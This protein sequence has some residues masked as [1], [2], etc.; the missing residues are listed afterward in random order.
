MFNVPKKLAVKVTGKLLGV[1]TTGVNFHEF[2]KLY[3]A[4][5][6]KFMDAN[7]NSELILQLYLGEIPT[8]HISSR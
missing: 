2:F 6:D 4:V 3:V 7:R 1:K 8:S 5:Y